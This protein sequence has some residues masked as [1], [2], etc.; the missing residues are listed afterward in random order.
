MNKPRTAW[1]NNLALIVAAFVGASPAI[2]QQAGRPPAK[3]LVGFSP[4]GTL[5]VVT[6]A[7][8]DQLHGPLDRTVVVENK[9]GA[10][11]KIAIDAMRAA[12]TD[13]S[14]AMLCPDFLASIYPF[15]FNKLNYDPQRDILPVST[16]V[17]FPMALAVPSSSPVKTFAEYAQWVRTHP[18]KANFGHAASGGPTHFLGLQIA[19]IIGTPLQDIPFQGAAPMIVNLT[20]ANVAAGTSTVGDFAQHHNAGKLRVLAVT[21]AQRSPL[22]PNVPTFGEL[23]RKELTA[24]GVL[25]IC[26]APGTPAA[27]VS[28][29]ST[30]VRKAASTEQFASKVRMLGFMNTGSSP[31][32]ARARFDEMRGFWEPVVKAS[33]FKAD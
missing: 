24:V 27:V 18:E 1:L 9:P 26:L 17:E 31:A 21:S 8:A 10:G 28:E 32:E 22:L 2:G 23:G 4:G 14:V 20:G 19:R 25:A 5:D 13:G 30:A 6:R 33:G 7:L 3:I 12:P 16:V 29:W 11:G 15:V